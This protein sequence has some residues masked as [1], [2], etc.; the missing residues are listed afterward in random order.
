MHTYTY[1]VIYFLKPLKKKKKVQ[2][3]AVYV[4]FVFTLSCLSFE[5]ERAEHHAVCGGRQDAPLVPQRC[6]I[7]FK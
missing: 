1:S 6:Y 4:T 2:K 3:T 7:S 5:Y